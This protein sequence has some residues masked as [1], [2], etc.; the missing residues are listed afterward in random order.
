[1]VYQVSQAVSIPIIGIGGIANGN[2]AIEFFLAG[3]NA[4]QVGT[5]VFVNPNV[6]NDIILQIKEYLIKNNYQ[7]INDIVGLAWKGN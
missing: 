2:D 3:A 6:H 5:S 1:M 4:V 7:S